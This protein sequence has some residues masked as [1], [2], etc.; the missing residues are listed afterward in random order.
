MSKRL[1]P[2]ALFTLAASALMPFDTAY[3]TNS[4]YWGTNPGPIHYVANVGTLFIP[5]DAKVGDPVGPIEQPFLQ[6]GGGLSIHCETDGTRLTFEAAAKAIPVPGPIARVNGTPM[7]GT[8]LETNIAGVGA[9]IKLGD[10]YDGF[11]AGY[12]KLSGSES[13]VPFNAFIDFSTPF[14]LQH[15]LLRGVITLVKTGPIGRGM[16]PLDSGKEMI[17]ASFTGLPNAFSLALSG[18]VTQAECT[19]SANPVSADPVKLGDWS[20]TQFTGEGDTT[21]PVPFSI[22]LNS[23]I[24]DPLPGGTV[25]NAHIRLEPM[26]GSTTIDADL[27][28][29]SLGSG[30]TARGV[31]I[32]ILGRDAA[33]PVTL[34][35]DVIQGAIPASGGMLLEFNALYYQTGATADVSPGSADASLAFTITY[36]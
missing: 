4:C 3:A 30:S 5:R 20:T 17:S 7:S 1:L 21:D 32:Q 34:N 15:S 12:W 27:G 6:S 19:L 13:T 26:A 22:A 23:C 16:Q 18:S 28:L 33:T 36:K 29:F 31:G 9:L 24:S 11:T 10:P 35:T 14:V 2:G 25:T 8:L